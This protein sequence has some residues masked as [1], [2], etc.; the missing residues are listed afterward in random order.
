M[1]TRPTTSAA[2]TTATSTSTASPRTRRPRRTRR[3]GSRSRTGAGR[4]CPFFIRTGKRLAATQTELRLVFKHAPKLGFQLRHEAARAEPARRQARSLARRPA[5][6]RRAPRRSGR[7]RLRSSS[8]WSSPRRAAR[9]RR[10]TRC[11]CTPRWSATARA[12]RARTGSRRPGGSC[13]RCS[14]RRRRCTRTRRARGARRKRTTLVAGHGR[15]HEPWVDVMSD[16]RDQRAHAP[17]RG[18]AVAVPADRRVRVPVRLPHGRARRVRTARSTGSASRASTRR[19]SSEACSTARPGFFRFAPFGINHPTAVVYVPGTNVLETTWK[20]PNGWIVVRDA[21]TM[22]PRDHEDTVTPHTRP[23]A[24][25]DADHM[26]VRTVE[27]LEG[28]VEVELICEPAFDYGRDAGDLGARRRRP[29]RGRCERRR[30]DVPPPYGSA[31]RDRGEP[32]P[33]PARA[34]GRRAGVLRALLGSGPRGARGR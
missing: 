21:L 9:G 17:E 28:N 22:G 4:A 13:S 6:P 20:T 26:L 19:A 18:R 3:S 29:T 16:D 11:S 15:W 8:T 31:A 2:S 23:P 34:P 7:D 30:A 25:D 24:D 14:T 32:R 10:R 33:C 27:C 12:S 1:P 5:R